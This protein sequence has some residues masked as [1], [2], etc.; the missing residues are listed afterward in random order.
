M[1]ASLVIVS[2]VLGLVAAWKTKD[3]R[4][5]IG[6]MLIFSGARPQR[7]GG[8]SLFHLRDWVHM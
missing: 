3:W 8:L 4:W 1:Q 5:I 7:E 2:G 6:A